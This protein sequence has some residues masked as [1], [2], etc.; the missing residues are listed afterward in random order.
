MVQ[1]RAC[2]SHEEKRNECRV[3]VGNPEGMILLGRR[4]KQENNIKIL[5]IKDDVVW[6]GFIW[7]RF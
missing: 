6:S 1:G 5:G 4:R 7:L 2:N 3:W